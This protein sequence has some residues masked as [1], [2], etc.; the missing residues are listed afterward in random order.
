MLETSGG[1]RDLDIARERFFGVTNVHRLYADH[2][3]L[4]FGEDVQFLLFDAIQGASEAD[5]A[6]KKGD[7]AASQTG[8]VE[9]TLSVTAIG[10][11]VKALSEHVPVVS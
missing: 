3:T 7:D 2:G 5:L 6:T 8:M 11:A 9:F 10:D 1:K 4:M